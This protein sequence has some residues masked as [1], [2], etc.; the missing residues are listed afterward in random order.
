MNARSK[1]HAVLNDESEGDRQPREF[2]AVAFF[3]LLNKDKDR[4]TKLAEKKNLKV[5][6]LPTRLV[7]AVQNTIVVSNDN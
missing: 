5:V 4:Y 3:N 1:R 7:K 2:K 6:N